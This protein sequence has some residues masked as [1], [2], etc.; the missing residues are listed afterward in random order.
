ME[1]ANFNGSVDMQTTVAAVRG[2][3]AAS[4]TEA[5]SSADTGLTD[6]SVERILTK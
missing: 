4:R 2:S 5:S 6:R 3:D 1:G